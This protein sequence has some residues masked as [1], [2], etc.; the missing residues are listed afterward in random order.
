MWKTTHNTGH[1]HHCCLFPS[2]CLCRIR[3]SVCFPPFVLTTLAFLP[4]ASCS[5][6]LLLL[7]AHTGTYRQLEGGIHQSLYPSKAELGTS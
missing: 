7:L 6:G 3:L 2:L 4:L 1:L 5:C